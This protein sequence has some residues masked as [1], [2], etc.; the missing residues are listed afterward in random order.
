MLP[1]KFVPYAQSLLP[2][3]PLLLES[4]VARCVQL[5][6]DHAENFDSID[7]FIQALDVL[8]V[9]GKIEIEDERIVYAD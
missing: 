1:N 6:V 5:Y 3:L 2:K 4:R 9:L 8:Y 7:E